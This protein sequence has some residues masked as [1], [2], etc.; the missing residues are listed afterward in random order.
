MTVVNYRDTTLNKN[1]QQCH[2]P[3]IYASNVDGISVICI[4]CIII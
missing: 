1:W 2:I 4:N 3:E